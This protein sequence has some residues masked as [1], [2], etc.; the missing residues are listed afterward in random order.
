VKK[1]ITRFFLLQGRPVKEDKLFQ[2]K[3]PETLW[4][5]IRRVVRNLTKLS[6]WKNRAL[7]TSVFGGKQNYDYW[8]TIF[9]SGKTPSGFQ[10]LPQG[11]NLDELLKD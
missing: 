2:Y 6:V 9:E 10:V 8:H 3:F 11:I 5:S 7:A 4:D 1:I